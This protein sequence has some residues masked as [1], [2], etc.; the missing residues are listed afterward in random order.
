MHEPT[1]RRALTGAIVKLLAAADFRQLR[2]VW[3]CVPPDRLNPDRTTSEPRETSP[4]N[5]KAAFPAAT[6]R[7]AQRAVFA[8]TN[9]APSLTKQEDFC[10]DYVSFYQCGTLSCVV[11]DRR[12]GLLVQ[13]EPLRR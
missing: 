3:V 8:T 6:G 4:S 1:T 10:N 2:L 11:P 13:R 5:K 9:T 7:A 12:C